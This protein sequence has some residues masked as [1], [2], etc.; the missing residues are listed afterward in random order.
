MILTILLIQLNSLNSLNSDDYMIF[1]Y[2]EDDY[3]LLPFETNINENIL[4]VSY[5]KPATFCLVNI[6]DSSDTFDN[7]IIDTTNGDEIASIGSINDGI[8]YQVTTEP[9]KIIDISV[10]FESE[11]KMKNAYRLLSKSGYLGLNQIDS[12]VLIKGY[13]AYGFEEKT[14]FINFDIKKK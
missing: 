7:E 4:S 14:C 10:T 1:Y 3:I 12:M 11:N 5:N 6:S 9:K 13:S 8:A 2:A